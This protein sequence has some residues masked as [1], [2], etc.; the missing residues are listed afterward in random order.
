MRSKRQEARGR[1][2]KLAGGLIGWGDRT[3]CR[4][5]GEEVL[6][7]TANTWVCRPVSEATRRLAHG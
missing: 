5:E 1:E 3:V 6:A 7:G 4:E 2:G